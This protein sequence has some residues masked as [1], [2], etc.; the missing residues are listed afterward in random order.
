MKKLTE[1]AVLLTLLMFVGAIAHVSSE[2]QTLIAQ[3]TA[4]C[5][6]SY[7]GAP[8]GTRTICLRFRLA[9]GEISTTGAGVGAICVDEIT[10]NLYKYVPPPPC[11]F[12]HNPIGGGGG[13]T[14]GGGTGSSGGGTSGGGGSGIGGCGDPDLW[15][16]DWSN[17]DTETQT[18]TT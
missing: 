11:T 16:D 14:G 3:E 4:T 7:T 1:K 9:S 5:G 12:C 13:S 18:S 10:I 17:C 15:T 2:R 8:C 6:S